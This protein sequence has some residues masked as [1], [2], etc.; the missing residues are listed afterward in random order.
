MAP[1]GRVID[2]SAE[3]TRNRRSRKKLDLFTSIVSSGKAW[4]A[5]VADDVW[6]DGDS[7][8]NFEV[9]DRGMNS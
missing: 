5:F 6:F 2:V 7:I 8:S 1:D 9:L 4:L 3:E